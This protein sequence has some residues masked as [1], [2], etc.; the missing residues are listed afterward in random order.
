[1]SFPRNILLELAQQSA[2]QSHDEGAE[3]GYWAG[4]R[5]GL[6]QNRCYIMGERE[7]NPYDDIPEEFNPFGD[8][9]IDM[10]DMREG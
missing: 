7:T 10:R 2:Y 6:E 3:D 1:M 4:Y 9:Y 8:R 5:D